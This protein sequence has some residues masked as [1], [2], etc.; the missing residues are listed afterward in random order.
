[1]KVSGRAA[2]EII[3]LAA[4]D[5]DKLVKEMNQLHQQHKKEIEDFGRKQKLWLKQVEEEGER[6][7]KEHLLKCG[8]HIS[9]IEELAKRIRSH[10]T[11]MK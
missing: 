11:Q 10:S 1:M 5:V 6:M 2:G 3:F 4:P 8:K 7:R 9:S